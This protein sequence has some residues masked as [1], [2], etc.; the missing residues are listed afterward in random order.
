MNWILMIALMVALTAFACAAPQPGL[1]PELPAASL[2][3]AVEK[4]PATAV[5]VEPEPAE[6]ASTP[7]PT[8]TVNPIVASDI[9]SY[10]ASLSYLAGKI[11]VAAASCPNDE[12]LAEY[13]QEVESVDFAQGDRTPEEVLMSRMEMWVIARETLT[14]LQAC[15]Q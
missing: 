4:D 15:Q 14:S 5:D 11:A 6:A 3:T 2:A 13:R 9:A 12:L 8:P 7:S 10:E 1:Q